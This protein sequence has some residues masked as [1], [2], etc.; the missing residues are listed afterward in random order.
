MKIKVRVFG[1]IASI[2]GNKHEIELKEN[3]TVLTLTNTLTQMAGQ[4]RQGFIGEFK[5][6]GADLAV[7][8]NGKN[9]ALLDGVQTVL[10]DK[11]DVVIMPFVVGG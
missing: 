11:D 10:A 9:I 6:G 8:I 4:T 3:A 5:V 7:M 2:V 1:D